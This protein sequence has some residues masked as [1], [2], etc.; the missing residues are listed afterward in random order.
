M[1]DISTALSGPIG[2]QRGNHLRL[3]MPQPSPADALKAIAREIDSSIH[4]HE[5]LS[6]PAPFHQLSVSQIPGTFG[7]GWPGLLYVS[8]FSFLPAET[9]ERAGL[10][11]S[12][13]EHFHD[14]V[15]F[16]EVAHQWWGNVVGW[17]SY[18]DQWIDEAMATYL[19]LLFADS[20]KSPDRT[21][22]VWLDRYRKRLADKGTGG[23]SPAETGSMI[24][25]SRLDSS[26][27]PEGF[28]ELVYGKGA[29]TFHMI[30]EMLREPGNKNP[31]ARFI[32][33]LRALQEKYAY[34]ALSTADLQHELEAVMN[35]GMAIE[36]RKSMEWFFSDWVR[37]TGIPH[38]R[39]EYSTKPAEKGFIVRGKLLQS[40]VPDS[41]VAPVPIYGSNGGYLGRIIASGPE[42]AFHF[43]ATRDPGKL[44]IDPRMTILCITER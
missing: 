33:L 44:I 19:S 13:Q 20:Q 17:S 9:Q 36:G 35:P 6:G 8:T 15:P 37:G 31:D 4:F 34:R 7:Q 1:D 43:S 39:V 42:T 21:L 29:W 10:N 2:A 3:Q 26:K 27:S 38:Y 18:R 12:T 5:N 30:R 24:L 32:G 11:T 22:R 23:F 28:D 40:G 41:F 25:G 16:H 14:L